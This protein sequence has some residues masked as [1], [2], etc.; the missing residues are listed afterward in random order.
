M[1]AQDFLEVI[2]SDPHDLTARLVYADW[3]DEQGDPRGEFV[4]VQCE[5]AQRD[6]QR[7]QKLLLRQREAD[8][9]NKYG[10]WW[11]ADYLGIAEAALGGARLEFYLGLPELPM[12]VTY[13]S[14]KAAIT[15]GKYVTVD[16]QI[17]ADNFQIRGEINPGSPVSVI[18][19]VNYSRNGL[20]SEEMVQRIESWGW[21]AGSL[22][23]LCGVG[24]MYPR[25][26]EQF[27][28]MAL[29]SSLVAG[30]EN[31]F[32][33]FLDYWPSPAKH[34]M[35]LCALDRHWSDNFRVIIIPRDSS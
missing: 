22:L 16:A 10:V 12:A 17:T 23:E 31:T 13:S 32:F 24:A 30:Y 19:F 1:R 14:L 34:R 21:R 28:I 35:I 27:V 20:R 3:L 4:R 26:Q 6:L 2:W 11:S 29:G 25:L 18:T 7:R 33:P 15:A 9:L 5:L 8:L